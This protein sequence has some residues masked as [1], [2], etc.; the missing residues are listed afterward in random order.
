[1]SYTAK[2]FSALVNALRANGITRPE[3]MARQPFRN[4]QG[5]WSAEVK[6]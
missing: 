2:S 6:A 3:Q 4:A 5:Y 1:M